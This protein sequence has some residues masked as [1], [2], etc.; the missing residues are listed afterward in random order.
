[1]LHLL[2]KLL[3]NFR[4]PLNAIGDSINLAARIEGL[5]K[6]LGTQ[7]LF[8]EA[9]RKDAGESTDSIVSM[10]DFRVKG[11][12][13]ASLLYTIF[14][15]PLAESVKARLNEGLK[16]FQ[17]GRLESAITLFEELPNLDIRLETFSK[18][19]LEYLR[20][21]MNKSDEKD[22]SGEVHLDEK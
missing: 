13:E 4:S 2:L 12:K 17:R 1:M 6:K 21:P 3:G 8:T 10:G 16:A 19:Y 7:L 14:T 5:N 15:P 22:W 11:K 9:V 20:D 18:F